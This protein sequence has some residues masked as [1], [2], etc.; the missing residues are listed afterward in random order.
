MAE[1]LLAHVLG[2]NRLSLYMETE[3]PASED[4]RAKLRDL[5]KRAMAHE[6]IQYLV[7]RETFYGLDFATDRR[8][9]IPRP[10][11]AT[12]LDEL[13]RVFPPPKR[14]SLLDKLDPG[15]PGN[16]DPPS[17]PES[18]PPLLLADIGTGTGCLA[19]TAAV[20]LPQA[21]THATDLSADA[22]DLA[23]TNA[24]THDVTDRVTFHRGDLLDALPADAKSFDAIVSNPPYIPDH[25]WDAVEPNVKDHEPHGALRAADGGLEF[26]APLIE[27]APALLKP[28]GLLLIELASCTA[29][30][31][32]ARAQRH[33]HLSD[34]SILK[35][36][37]ALPC[38]LSA[39]LT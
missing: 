35:D 17:E 21:K 37:D 26:V 30:D 28:G 23:R 16:D 10:S 9:L 24:E 14:R 1:L 33:P 3:R 19:I 11:S 29:E 12:I 32:L 15:E 36:S 20:R 39:R 8:A 18:A 31:C 13:L 34:V 5:V 7:G 2:C 6:P 38:V 27:H 25:E 4:E 22:L